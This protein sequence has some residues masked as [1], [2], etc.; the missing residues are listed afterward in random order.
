MTPDKRGVRKSQTN[1]AAAELRIADAAALLPWNSNSFHVIGQTTPDGFTPNP[2]MDKVQVRGGVVSVLHGQHMSSRDSAFAVMLDEDTA[3]AKQLATCTDLP[4]VWEFATTGFT[5]GTIAA[6]STSILL[7]IAGAQTAGLTTD[8]MIYI[9]HNDGELTEMEEEVYVKN[10]TGSQ[11]TL[12]NKLSVTP[13][14]DTP[15]K[16]VRHYNIAEGGT[17]Y[18]ELT[19]NLKNTLI[20][21]SLDIIHYPDARIDSGKKNPGSNSKVRGVELNFTAVSV[22]ETIEG[23]EEPVFSREY[24]VPRKEVAD[25]EVV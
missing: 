10:V 5:L 21:G 6:G 25:M 23:N 7:S 20:D 15:V 16:R 12:Y 22:A 1:T 18:E 4:P 13:A 2:S 17:N 24:L 19:V 11:V 14:A 8:H 9:K 3:R